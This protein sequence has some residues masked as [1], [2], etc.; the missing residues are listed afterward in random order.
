RRGAASSARDSSSPARWRRTRWSSFSSLRPRP[1]KTLSLRRPSM[2]HS[3]DG[4]DR[5]AELSR[6]NLLSPLKHRDFRVLWTG[7]AV[8]LIGDGIFL[9]AVAWESYALWNAPA[10]LAIVGIAITV[11]MIAFL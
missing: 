4:L 2:Q 11:P 5:P 7:M 6:G 8:S 3:Y 9:I 10:S 1:P